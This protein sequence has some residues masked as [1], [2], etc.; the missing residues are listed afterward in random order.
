M[1]KR[2]ILALLVVFSAFFLGCVAP[3]VGPGSRMTI[4]CTGD[5]WGFL[6]PTG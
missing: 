4:L 1:R 6:V 3:Q 5:T 2:W